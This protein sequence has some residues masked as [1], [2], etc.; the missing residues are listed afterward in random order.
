VD[1]DVEHADATRAAYHECGT[2]G[3]VTLN[4]QLRWILWAGTV[5]FDSPLPA[6]FDAAAEVGY[7]RVSLSPPEVKR[8]ADSGIA[9]NQ[10]GR[11]ARDRGLELIIDP[12]MNWYPDHAPSPA[13]SRFAGVSADDA[14]RMTEALGAAAMT[15]IATPTSD[16]PAADLAEPFAR[17]CD[18][19]AAFGSDVQLEFMPFTV[20]RTL[21]VAWDIIRTAAR[22]NGGLVF[23]T[24]H[25]FRGEPEFELLETVAGER[26]FCVQLDDAAAEPQGTLR[27]DTNRRLMPGDG[28]FDLTRVVRVLDRIGALRWVGP[29]VINPE[30]AALPV[31]HVAH[32]AM[33]K[34]RV[35]LDAALS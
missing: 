12:V 7:D 14:L 15:V 28:T 13:R 11:G 18:R 23:D 25:F 17:I 10:I 24:W 21:G 4:R 31:E 8:A 5:G 22:H 26:I 29:E 16:V 34:V 33:E 27:E 9:V 1:Y 2:T 3:E 19:A 30:L 35:V 6:R 32:L 20:V